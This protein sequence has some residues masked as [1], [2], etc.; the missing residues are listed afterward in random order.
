MTGTI[1]RFPDWQGVKA[2]DW[3]LSPVPNRRIPPASQIL[4]QAAS[5]QYGE[6]PTPLQV[7]RRWSM[8][9]D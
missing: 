2:A 1:N 8:H 6:R 4:N 9:M 3:K 5:L 7:T